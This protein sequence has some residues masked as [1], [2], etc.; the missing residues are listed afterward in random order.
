ML[1]PCLQ[2]VGPA[3]AIFFGKAVSGALGRGGFQVVQVAGTFLKLHH[4]LPNMVQQTQGKAVPPRRAKILLVLGKVADHLVNAVNSQCGEVIAQGAQIAACVGKQPL[5]HMLLDHRALDFQA[6]AA[7]FQQFIQTGKQSG[8]IALIQMTQAGAVQGDHSQGASLFGR[9]K[10]AITAFEQLAQIQLQAAAHGADHIGFQ[11]GVNEVLEVGQA[12]FGRHGKQALGIRAVPVKIPGDVVGGDRKGEGTATGI[13]LAHD[14]DIGLVDH[15][16]FGL[17]IPVAKRHF[18]ATDLRNL[19][20]QVVGAHPVKGQIGKGRL[21]PP[22]RGYVQV[23]DQFL[24]ALAHLLVAQAVLADEGRHIGIKGAE[25]L[26]TGPFVLQGAQ[27][28]DD[29]TDRTA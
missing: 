4:A 1:G 16:H 8:F 5:V 21:C 9:A 25:G 27:E 23:V 14:F 28:I 11:L 22:A 15:V 19:L 13:A 2:N 18:F 26:G 12:I 17:Q 20:A 3:G 6:V 7:H 24:H 29:L 10:Q